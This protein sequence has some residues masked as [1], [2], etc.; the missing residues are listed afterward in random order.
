[1]GRI[2]ADGRDD[3][4]VGAGGAD[5]GGVN[6]RGSATVYSGLDAS[7]IPGFRIY[8]DSAGDQLGS[9]VANA[10][11]VDGNGK[12][13]F[14]VGARFADSSGADRGAVYLFSGTNAQ[15]L[16]RRR[17]TAAGERMGQSVSGGK[18]VNG[19]GKA[20]F[21]FGAPQASPGGLEDAGTVYVVVNCPRKK[22]DINGDGQFTG[23][24]VTEEHY[25]KVNPAGANCNR[26]W[27]DMDCDGD[28]DQTDIDILT[29]FVYSAIPLPCP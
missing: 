24:D 19:D 9:S 27:A 20:D 4:I 26:C 12:N 1:M 3:F 25:C 13:D 2:D 5:S 14:V 23:A 11:D 17:G 15:L 8:G 28:I 6:N 22:G 18:D 29:D 16:T 10:G 7:I 21:I